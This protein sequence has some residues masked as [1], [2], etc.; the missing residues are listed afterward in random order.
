EGFY[1]RNN[2]S[3]VHFLFEDIFDFEL[4]GFNQQNVLLS[5][6]L[7]VVQ[8]PMGSNHALHVEL[9]HCY[10]FSGEFSARR[11]KVLGIAPYVAR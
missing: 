9:E 1:K 7:S 11:A 3:V 5:L 2:D 10:Q 8:D 6:N 4:E